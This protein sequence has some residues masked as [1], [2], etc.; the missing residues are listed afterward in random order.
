MALDVFLKALGQPLTFA[1]RAG[2]FCNPWAIASLK[3]KE[4]PNSFV[5]AWWLN[6]H[7]THGFGDTFLKILLHS[8]KNE[9][10]LGFPQVISPYC[11]VSV[12]SHPDGNT[13][14]RVDIEINDPGFFLIIEVKIDALEG[15]D[16]L[17]RYCQ[18]AS[19][20]SKGRPW[21]VLYLTP[22]NPKISRATRD[23]KI[24]DINKTRVIPIS[25]KQMASLLNTALRSHTDIF[26][27]K[28]FPEL[29]LVNLLARSFANHINQ[30]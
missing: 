20:R 18:I 15:R 22:Q 1:K 23:S 9:L 10:F 24:D 6:P 12:E 7:G 19:K 21:A 30:F 17:S 25:W 5:L 26:Q 13:E 14:N 4:V 3:R 16:Q 29:A 27:N 11:R 28:Q 2:F 8:I